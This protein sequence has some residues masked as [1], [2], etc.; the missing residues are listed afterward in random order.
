MRT[1]HDLQEDDRSRVGEQVAAQRARVAARLAEVR[2]LLAVVSGK[3]GVGK[4]WVTALLAQALAARLDGR[5]AVLDADLKSPTIARMLGATGPLD[6][7]AEGVHPATGRGG[8]AVMSTDLLL[9]EGAPLAWR[10]AAPEGFS[11]RGLLE[12]GVLREFFADVVWDRREV[13]LVDMPP[14]VD[15]LDDLEALA[16]HRVRCVVV[17]IPTEESRRSVARTMRRA[18]DEGVPILG[19]IENMS[20][21]A[22]ADCGRTGPLFSG[23]AATALC[24]EFGV[25]LLGRLPFFPRGLPANPASALGAVGETLL[26]QLR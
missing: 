20:G 22:C 12:V 3:G 15:R 18:I 23:D 16:P 21:Y 5:V 9:A 14:D 19:V 26:E 10:T 11:W 1:Y 25:P 4:S 13:L 17:T 2:H 8:V 7:T 24:A 6:V